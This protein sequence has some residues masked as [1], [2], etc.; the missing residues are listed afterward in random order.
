MTQRGLQILGEARLLSP[1]HPA[2]V[3]AEVKPFLAFQ[4][5]AKVGSLYSDEISGRIPVS[6]SSY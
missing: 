6:E 1:E 5:A 2:V 4:A 3:L